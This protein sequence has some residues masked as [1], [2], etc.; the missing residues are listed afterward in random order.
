[1]KIIA[2]IP[3]RFE[4][5]RFPGKPLALLQGKSIIQ[6]V[7]DNVTATGLFQD[8]IVATDSEKIFQAVRSFNGKVM[9]TSADHKSGT[10]RV[11]EVC[12][13]LD[14][15]I[16]INIQGDEPFLSRE[17]LRDLIECFSDTSVEIASLMHEFQEDPNNPSYVKVI[18]DKFNNALYFSRSVIPHNR[19]KQFVKY[20]HHVGVYAFRKNALAEFVS[21]P[22]GKLESIEKL[23]QLRLLENGKKIRMV[24]TTYSGFGID[25]ESDL[26]K[27]ESI[28]LDSGII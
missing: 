17:P 6:H 8:V 26:E 10:D 14:F 3:A 1:M 2:V 12:N 5:T 28:L 7:Y 4:S 18:T 22:P 20:Y 16:V 23:E 25:T 21:F 11:A 27:A 24:K 19:D 13:N 15:D 9:M